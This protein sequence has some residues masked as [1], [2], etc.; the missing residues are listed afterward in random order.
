VGI[1]VTFEAEA[2]DSWFSSMISDVVRFYTLSNAACT[3]Y[4]TA[5]LNLIPDSLLA[6][7][8]ACNL[9]KAYRHICFPVTSRDNYFTGGQ[10]LAKI[11]KASSMLCKFS[12]A[13]L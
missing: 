8:Q 7:L 1:T 13:A 2:V 6:V 3:D 4:F 5:I 12:T 10:V 9:N 11:G